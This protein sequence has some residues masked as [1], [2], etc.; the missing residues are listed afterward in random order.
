MKK[1]IIRTKQCPACGASIAAN[2]RYCPYC[3]VE[4]TDIAPMPAEVYKELMQRIKKIEKVLESYKFTFK[5]VNYSRVSIAFLFL[6]PIGLA[7]VMHILLK[8]WLFSAVCLTAFSLLAAIRIKSS[9]YRYF[10]GKLME[11]LEWKYVLKLKI[12]AFLNKNQLPMSAYYEAVHDYLDGK[13]Y[14]LFSELNVT[15][16]EW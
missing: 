8:D 5:A 2:L 15:L 1:I 10:T 6:F 14:P 4:Q 13:K 7:L 16:D 3:E 11:R 9:N 12:K